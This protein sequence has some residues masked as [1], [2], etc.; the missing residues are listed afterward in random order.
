MV[1]AS[2]EAVMLDFA[3]EFRAEGDDRFDLLLDE[4]D[5]Y[6]ELAARFEDDRDLPEDRVPMSHFLF[7]ADDHLVGMSR[8]RRRLLPVLELDGGH[9]GY[10]V[11]RSERQKGYGAEILRQSLIEASRLQIAKALLTTAI[12]NVPSTRLIEGAGGVFDG[13]TVSPRT[14]DTM[15]RY[16]VPTPRERIRKA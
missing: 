1:R 12:T 2:H 13:L 3:R 15:R 4:P 14:G 10:E 16:W 11:R 8:L 7:F 6:F 9:I 5:E